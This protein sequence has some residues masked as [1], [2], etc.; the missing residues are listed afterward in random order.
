MVWDTNGNIT[1]LETLGGNYSCGAAVNEM[2][3]VAG[4][5]ES[6]PGQWNLFLWDRTNGM[7]DLSSLGMYIPEIM[8]INNHGQIIANYQSHDNRA[9]FY[10]N[11]TGLVDLITLLPEDCGW[12]ISGVSAINNHGQILGMG[13]INGEDH[14]FLMTPVPEPSASI[15]LLVLAGLFGQRLRSAGA[16]RVKP[17]LS[18]TDFHLRARYLRHRISRG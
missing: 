14:I 15:C 7:V 3:Q 11:E 6:T 18:S 13:V 12:S 5:S 10:S 2:G 1:D 4:W 9:I 17:E 16:A 8:G